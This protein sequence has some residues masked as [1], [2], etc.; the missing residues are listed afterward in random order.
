ME[1]LH[2]LLRQPHVQLA[3]VLS[4]CQRGG[5]GRGG[6]GRG[7]EGRGGEGRGGEGRGGEGRGGEGRGGE[8]CHSESPLWSC[9]TRVRLS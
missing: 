7:E 6:E 8:D 2:H 3:D 4:I 9:N 1:F 5:E